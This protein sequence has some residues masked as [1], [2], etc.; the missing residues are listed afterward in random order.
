MNMTQCYFRATITLRPCTCFALSNSGLK[1]LSSEHTAI[2]WPMLRN[3]LVQDLRPAALRFRRFR[4]LLR[5]CT[6]TPRRCTHTGSDASRGPAETSSGSIPSSKQ[7]I[8]SA[9]G[10]RPAR[11]TFHLSH[12]YLPGPRATSASDN[13]VEEDGI[14]DAD[15]SVDDE[16]NSAHNTLMITR[17]PEDAIL[18]DLTSLLQGYGECV[19]N[20]RTCALHSSSAAALTLRHRRRHGGPQQGICTCRVQ[21]AE[22]RSEG[23][24]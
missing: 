5:D 9:S 17:I 12:V 7:W 11:D 3:V 8:A 2:V 23:H 20:M 16:G 1:P 24:A 4:K 18:D 6:S 13:S 21:E 22:G 14:P 19:V 10:T 15:V